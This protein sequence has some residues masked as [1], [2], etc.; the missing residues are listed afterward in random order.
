MNAAQT[1]PLPLGI[2]RCFP[3]RS[4]LYFAMTR[5]LSTLACELHLLFLLV[6]V[7]GPLFSVG[8]QDTLGLG[9][10]PLCTGYAALG[11]LRAPAWGFCEQ[12]VQTDPK[13]LCCMC[14][15]LG[16]TRIL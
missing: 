8:H 16:I 3:D 1:R 4:G 15:S 6:Y 2:K 7:L 9:S 13:V 11:K 5:S 10:D 14:E 12:K